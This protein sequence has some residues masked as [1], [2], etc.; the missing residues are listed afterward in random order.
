ML[1]CWF[2]YPCFGGFL[3]TRLQIGEVADRYRGQ[4]CFALVGTFECFSWMSLSVRKTMVSVLSGGKSDPTFV[5]LFLMQT[6]IHKSIVIAR[7]YHLT[8]GE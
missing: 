2:L 6:A 8:L 7:N 1:S 3:E 5:G 4:S